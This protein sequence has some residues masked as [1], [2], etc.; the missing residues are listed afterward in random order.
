MRKRAAKREDFPAPD[1]PHIPTLVPAS[2]V[3]ETSLGEKWT[4]TKEG[5]RLDVST[6]C[7]D[8]LSHPA[9]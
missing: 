1:L 8:G 6:V 9:L 3:K 5:V 4:G 2:A 7:S